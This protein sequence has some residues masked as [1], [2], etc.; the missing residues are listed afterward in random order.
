VEISINIAMVDITV[1]KENHGFTAREQKIFE[2]LLL[3]L[4]AHANA[5]I[6]KDGMAFLPLEK[7]AQDLFS[8]QF[9]WQKSLSQEQ[10][11][12]FYESVKSRYETAFKMTEMDHMK[13]S[14]LENAYLNN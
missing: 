4:A 2:V 14:F 6:T 9:A 1:S 12:E 3:N 11:Q 10:Y 13:I 8:Y 5:M 7:N